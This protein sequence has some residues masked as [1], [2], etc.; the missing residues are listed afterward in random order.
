MEREEKRNSLPLEKSEMQVERERREVVGEGLLSPEAFENVPAA[1]RQERIR[2][3]EFMVLPPPSSVTCTRTSPR[4]SS[5]LCSQRALS[6]PAHGLSS[7]NFPRALH[8]P[9]QIYLFYL[10]TAM[11][12][13][14]VI[15]KAEMCI[16]RNASLTLL[17]P[18]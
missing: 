17:V 6:L 2:K 13:L 5:A 4:N 3:R 9:G 16:S 15:P 8:Q 1:P 10:T 14:T 7:F 18:W 12:Q 11:I